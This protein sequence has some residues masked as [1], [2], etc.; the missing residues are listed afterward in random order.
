MKKKLVVLSLFA[1]LLVRPAHADE[2]LRTVAESSNF[3]AT[4][5]HAEVMAY[6][7]R[8]AKLSPLVRLGALGTSF[9]KRKL[10]LLILADPPIAAPEEAAASGKLVVFAMGNIHAGE[11]DGKEGLLML[12]RDLATAKER[13]LLKHL[14]IVIAPIFNADG[15]ERFSKTNRPGQAGPAEGMGVRPNAQ[16]LDLN[17]DFV[18]LESPEVRALVRFCNK[19][20]PAILDVLHKAQEIDRAAQRCGLLAESNAVGWLRLV[21]CA[22]GGLACLRE[23]FANLI[24]VVC[25]ILE[26]AADKIARSENAIMIGGIRIRL[27][28]N[29]HLIAQAKI[30]YPEARDGRDALPARAIAVEIAIEKR[31]EAGMFGQP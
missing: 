17:R 29:A 27:G 10:P 12:A 23:D 18:K 8:L 19:W 6:C 15:N 9:E 1:C 20:E 16:Q 28:K 26:D 22:Y 21:A 7:E 25:R 14:V 5:R 24:V 4:S 31:L 2:P 3:R 30:V 11:V 13:P